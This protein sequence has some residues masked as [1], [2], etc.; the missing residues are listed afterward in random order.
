MTSEPAG[1]S[2]G[3]PSRRTLL[4]GAAAGA[5]ALAAGAAG[6]ADAAAPGAADAL[7]GSGTALAPAAA[8]S[9]WNTCLDV[10]RA[11]LVRDEQ[12]QPLVPRYR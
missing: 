2:S 11:I 3:L 7:P 5:A 6:T 4:T 10:A 8:A 12:D 9:D 1:P